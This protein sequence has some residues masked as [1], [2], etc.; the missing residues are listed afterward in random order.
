MIHQGAA[1]MNDFASYENTYGLL[2]L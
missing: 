2:L 1:P